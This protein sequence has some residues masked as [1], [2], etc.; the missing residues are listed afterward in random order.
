[1]NILRGVQARNK[2]PF[3][4]ALVEYSKQPPAFST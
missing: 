3:F 1:M 4:T 2:T